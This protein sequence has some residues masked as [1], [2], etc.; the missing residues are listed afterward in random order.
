MR[1]SQRSGGG[2]SHAVHIASVRMYYRLELGHEEVEF[3][4]VGGE[5]IP[6]RGDRVNI[7]WEMRIW[8]LASRYL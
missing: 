8:N 6:G 2:Q 1:S 5:G 7:G 3:R 4:W